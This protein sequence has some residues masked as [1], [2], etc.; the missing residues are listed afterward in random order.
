MHKS[1]ICDIK[2]AISL[3]RSS[4]QPKVLQSAYRDSCT[5][6]RLVANLVTWSELWPTFRG[7]KFFHDGYLAHFAV[8]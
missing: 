3:K 5:A 4:L 1:G 8:A 6:Y 7:A 2:P